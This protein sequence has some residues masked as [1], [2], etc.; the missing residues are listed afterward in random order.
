MIDL[1][2]LPIFPCNLAKEPLTAHG[3]KDAK[4]GVSQKGWPLIGFAT[5]AASGID[6][7]DIDPEGRKWF[8]VNFD[9]LPTTRAHSTQRG[10]HLLFKHALGLGCSTDKIADGIDVRADGGYAIYWP[11]TGL[12]LEDAPIAEWPDWLL[13]EAK[14]IRRHRYLRRSFPARHDHDPVVVADRI[15]AL[16]E[17]D[18]CDWRGEFDRWFELLM[19][20]KYVGITLEDWVEWCVSDPEYANDADE[21]ARIWCS[22]EA[23]HGG[24]FYAALKA[25]GI[26]VST[27]KETSEVPNEARSALK[28][29]LAHQPTL[30]I[31]ARLNNICRRLADNPNES[32]LFSWGCL[33]ARIVDEC[34]LNPTRVMR[35]LEAAASQTSL[36]QAL[37]RDGIRTTISRAFTHVEEKLLSNAR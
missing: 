3:F 15:T 4:S 20:C 8:D 34:K 10:L 33:C 7:L 27:H 23:K 2:Q 21:I 22:A 12:P 19:A 6:I 30:N 37:G 31:G 16:R 25:R 32:A 35:L 26:R 24:A 17:M 29:A 36:R 1:G 14:G 5:G 18:A 13:A 11:A 28:S 9:A